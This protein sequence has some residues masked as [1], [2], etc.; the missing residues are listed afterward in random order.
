MIDHYDYYSLKQKVKL[1]RRIVFY[2]TTYQTPHFEFN[3]DYFNKVK[4]KYSEII[5]L[6]LT[7][8]CEYRHDY[9]S[10][11]YIN[12]FTN[13]SRKVRNGIVKKIYLRYFLMKKKF[14][15]K[16]IR[17]DRKGYTHISDLDL[18][19]ILKTYCTTEFK[20]SQLVNNSYTSF[21]ISDIKNIFSS[22][23]EFLRLMKFKVS[24]VFVL[25]NGRLPI[26]H[27]IKLSLSKLQYD[28][29]IFHE[30]N[31]F[32][33]KVFYLTH[34]PHDLSKFSKL[35]LDYK[36]S[37]KNLENKWINTKKPKILRSKK[38]FITYFTSSN[39]EYQFAYDKPIKQKLIIDKL[40]K[41]TD[42]G[43]P[44]KIRV[45]PNTKNKS[46]VE[47]N[48]WSDL[49]AKNSS[50]VIDYNE[51]IN[52]YDLIQK[53]I[54]TLSIGSSVAAES[55]VL[56]VPHILIGRQNWYHNLNI[57]CNT[58][59][60]NFIN[61]IKEKYNNV[62]K[63]NIITSKKRELAAASLLFIRD[64]GYK[65]WIHPFGTYPTKGTYDV[66]LRGTYKK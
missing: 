61:V 26:E 23:T 30:C 43:Y 24:D 18:K 35:I 66:K 39:D 62:N 19:K 12:F 52:A 2:I 4:D 17:F 11:N 25:F 31:Q 38:L 21:I 1:D 22:N 32:E 7:E 34:S 49:K 33:K 20:S 10:R 40:L 56:G 57:C 60:V 41:L 65:I 29:I 44:I 36:N 59:P 46:S 3:F 6:D 48:Y 37:N 55:I 8:Y 16:R 9:S 47:K 63:F 50:V 42:E 5:F 13:F 28:K 58:E 54:F 64:I 45:H 51:N 27:S 53:S 15:H 14:S